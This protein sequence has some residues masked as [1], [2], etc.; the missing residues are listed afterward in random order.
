MAPAGRG[1]FSQA[2]HF[3]GGGSFDVSPPE[4]EDDD[5]E[6]ELLEDELFEDDEE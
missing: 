4:E 3:S 5:D 6:C 1:S 2:T